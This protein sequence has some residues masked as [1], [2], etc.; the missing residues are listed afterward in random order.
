MLEVELLPGDG[1]LLAPDWVPWA[2]RLAEMQGAGGA[3]TQ[4][5]D[6][7]D[8]ES[9]DDDDDDEDSDDD[10][11]DDESD[12]DDVDDDDDS[13]DD[14]A[15]GRPRRRRRRRRHRRAG[16]RDDDDDDSTGRR[17]G[18]PTSPTIRRAPE[19]D[20]DDDSHDDELGR[21]G[22]R[23]AAARRADLTRPLTRASSAGPAGAACTTAPTPRGAGACRRAGVRSAGRR[24]RSS[25][26]RIS[27]RTSS[28]SIA[29][30][31]ATRSW[32]R[33]SLRYGSVST[34]PFARSVAATAAASIDVV[35]VDRGDDLRAVRRVGDERASR[36][37]RR[38]G[39]VVERR[40]RL[41]GA[42]VGPGE[43]AVARCIQRVWS[44]SSSSV[45][46]AGVFSVWSSRELSTAFLRLRNS[47]MYR[48]LA[49]IRSMRSIAAGENSA[50]QRP[51]SEAKFFC[52]AK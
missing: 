45:V 51:P 35:E 48:P 50:S 21:R 3:A 20:A 32:L 9:D 28:G 11:D 49:A 44:S 2:E 26:E 24:P 47:G 18:R 31:V 43:A 27:W 4:D 40:R 22:R 14:D 34:M 15:V 19:A 7:D 6:D 36:T 30:K 12:D 29:V 38:L 10:D 5:D 39:P 16:R 17:L 46:S 33:P 13:D 52:G 1:A 41:A 25:I 37:R 23:P 8:D 42:G